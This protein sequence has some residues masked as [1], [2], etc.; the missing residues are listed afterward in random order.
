MSRS[1]NHTAT[2]LGCRLLASISVIGALIV[3][4]AVIAIQQRPAA[5][6]SASHF[7][8]LAPG[9]QADATRRT[10]VVAPGGAG[11]PNFK[12]TDTLL[13]TS[14]VDGQL[15]SQAVQ[16]V[17]RTDANCQPDE[18]GISHCLNELAVGESTIMVRHHH[19]MSEVPCLTPGETVMLLTLDQYKRL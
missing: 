18:D 14:L 1:K 10:V 3:I 13:L 19:K 2:G 7:V 4:L 16:A 15:P 12:A 17:V 11:L 6:A 8:E 5:P 9:S